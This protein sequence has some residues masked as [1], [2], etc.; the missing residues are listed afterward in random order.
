MYYFWITFI[1]IFIIIYL[2]FAEKTEMYQTKN[3][4]ILIVV[5]SKQN[6]LERWNSE[7]QFWV[8]Y[9]EYGKKFNIDVVF[10]ECQ[11]NF[12]SK[13]SCHESYIPGIFQKTILTLSHYKNYDFYVRT[14]LSTVY[15]FPYLQKYIQDNFK[16]TSRK[17]IVSGH[18]NSWGISGTGILM[19]RKARDLLVTKGRKR[20][21]FEINKQYDDV[22]I[23]KLFKKYHAKFICKPFL[24][25]WNKHTSIEEN[26]QTVQH[27]YYPSIRLRFDH[28]NIGL[29]QGICRRI[30]QHFY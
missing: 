17:P 21:Y 5:I 1:S 8:M 22:V 19:N 26:L 29:Y 11:E 20:K 9:Q 10:S 27:N 30:C 23:G 14:N 15:I 12:T 13:E 24:Y 3:P 25:M 6:E 2:C 28:D 18:C 16:R 7:K 4:S